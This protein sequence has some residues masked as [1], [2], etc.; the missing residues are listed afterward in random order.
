MNCRAYGRVN[1]QAAS[2][3]DKDTQRSPHQGPLLFITRS[4]NQMHGNNHLLERSPRGTHCESG[5]YS[6]P[7]MLLQAH[8]CIVQGQRLH[9]VRGSAEHGGCRF[10]GDVNGC[11]QLV[12]QKHRIGGSLHLRHSGWAAHYAGLLHVSPVS[13]LH[14]GDV[15]SQGCTSKMVA[16]FLGPACPRRRG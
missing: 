3:D 6:R 10:T 4:H 1:E 12:H 11:F 9:S 7:M 13:E 15:S 16:V 5:H 14:A 8:S 2:K